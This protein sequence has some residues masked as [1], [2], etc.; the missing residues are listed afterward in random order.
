VNRAALERDNWFVNPAAERP[1]LP[2][3]PGRRGR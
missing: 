3:R 1:A 2:A